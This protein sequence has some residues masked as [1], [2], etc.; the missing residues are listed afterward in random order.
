MENISPLGQSK[1]FWIDGEYVMSFSTYEKLGKSCK[2]ADLITDDGFRW[3]FILEENL[4]SRKK[5]IEISS[6]KRERKFAV[7]EIN[8]RIVKKVIAES[9]DIRQAD[10]HIHYVDLSRMFPF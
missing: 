6:K 5:Y 3:K 2:T 1:C 8:Q 9:L 7:Q 4:D 10:I